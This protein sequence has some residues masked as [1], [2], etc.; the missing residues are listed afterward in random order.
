V[1]GQAAQPV[2]YMV[3]FDPGM[4][5]E[6]VETGSLAIRASGAVLAEISLED[7]RTL[8]SVTRTMSV[9]S[10]SGV[11]QQNFK[12]TLLSN[13][14]GLVDPGLMEKYSQVLAIGVSDYI[15][16]ISMEEIRAEDSVFIM[17]EDNGEPLPKK[18]GEPGA[19]RIVAVNEVFG[20]RFADYLLEI[21][22]ED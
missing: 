8:P 10:R 19:M 14:I 18:N 21:E 16:G 12:G 4:G 20:Q 17:Y 15:T 7:I 2:P 5:D 9:H 13:I 11:T 3:R 22:L 6:L 1:L